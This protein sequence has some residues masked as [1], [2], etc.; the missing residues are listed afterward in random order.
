MKTYIKPVVEVKEFNVMNNIASLDSFL[1]GNTPVDGA[2]VNT[3]I[4]AEN[5]TSYS[6]LS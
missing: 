2:A 5:I 4:T 3:I 1:A 6:A